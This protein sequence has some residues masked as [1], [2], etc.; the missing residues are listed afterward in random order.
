VGPHWWWVT[1]QG[2]LPVFQTGLL[3]PSGED[4]KASKFKATE[5]HFEEQGLA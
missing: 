3:P 5:F 2:L 4:Y 1:A